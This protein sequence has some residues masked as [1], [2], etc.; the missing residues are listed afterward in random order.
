MMQQSENSL[1]TSSESSLHDLIKQLE[2][3]SIQWQQ[4]NDTSIQGLET[5]LS[6]LT[7]TWSQLQAHK[8]TWLFSHIVLTHE[9]NVLDVHSHK[10]AEGIDRSQEWLGH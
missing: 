2:E 5:Q 9:G 1:V 7:S 3:S 8:S 10:L 6:Q 4:R